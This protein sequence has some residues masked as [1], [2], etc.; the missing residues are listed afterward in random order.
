M[1]ISAAYFSNW[2]VYQKAFFV[3]DLPVQKL[4]HVFYAFIGM[5]EA[6][7]A[8]KLSDEWA[9][10]QLPM[11][12][13]L[14]DAKG[15]LQQLFQCK[16]ANRGLKTLA[17]VGGWGSAGAFSQILDSNKK[18]DVFVTTAVQLVQAYG[19][20]GLDIDWEYPQSKAE[21]AKLLSLLTALRAELSRVLP[22]SLLTIASPAGQQS[23]GYLDLPQIDRYV[24]FWNAMCYDFAGLGWSQKTGF[25]SNLFGANGDNELNAAST[26]DYYIRHGVQRHKLVMGMPLYGRVFLHPV[27]PRIGERYLTDGVPGVEHTTTD[28]KTIVGLNA[29]K[30]FDPRKVAAFCY[31][32]DKNLFITYD[33][34]QSARIKAQ[35][36]VLQGLG[37]GM[38]WDSCGDVEGEQSL[39]SEFVSQLGG[40]GVLENSR[41]RVE[42]NSEYLRS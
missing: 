34:M 21:G 11:K 23:L 1:Y 3:K 40:R 26:L 16:K 29:Q 42:Y 37:G 28:Y 41:N 6:T 35:Y 14:G 9:D 7:G 25:H 39:I 4:T 19:F 22:G 36:V 30:Q 33:N 13:H 17:S 8:V 15:S 12:S 38:W 31:D 32:A 18:T 2:L 20:D 27:A 24:S 10:T 5:D